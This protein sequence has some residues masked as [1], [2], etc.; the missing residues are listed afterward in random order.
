MIDFDTRFG[1]VKGGSSTQTQFIP[2]FGV[3]GNPESMFLFGCV[4]NWVGG[5]V[6]VVVSSSS[7]SSSSSTC[8]TCSM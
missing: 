2:K 4:L 1:P 7:S 6:V 3:S 5:A 8:S